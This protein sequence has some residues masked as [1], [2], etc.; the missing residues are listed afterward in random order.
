[1]T[2][3]AIDAHARTRD[4]RRGGESG[5]RPSKGGGGRQPAADEGGRGDA[6]SKGENDDYKTQ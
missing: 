3:G 1:M 5:G 2:P 4:E 6:I